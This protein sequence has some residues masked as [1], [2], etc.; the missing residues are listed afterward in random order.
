MEWTINRLSGH[1]GALMTGQR[2]KGADTATLDGV[3]DA[4]FA[5]GVVV[6]PG[7]HLE[8]EDHIRLATHFGDID[9]NRF[10]PLSL[11]FR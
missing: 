9:V 2:L 5:H 1:V 8:P 4:L 3:R 6:L 11:N 7:Q 10:L